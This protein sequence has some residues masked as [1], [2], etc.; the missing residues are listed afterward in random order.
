MLDR[1]VKINQSSFFL[2]NLNENYELNLHVQKRIKNNTIQQSPPSKIKYYKSIARI[3][4][5]SKRQME[6]FLLLY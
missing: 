1:S 6:P 3:I 2:K 4:C 5:S